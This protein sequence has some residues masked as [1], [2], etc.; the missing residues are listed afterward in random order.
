[1]KKLFLLFLVIFL[2]GCIAN[3]T[4]STNEKFLSKSWS[5]NSFWKWGELVG[6]A[7]LIALFI[8]VLAYFAGSFFTSPELL[9]WSKKEIGQLIYSC[10][11][12]IFVLAL[13]ASV[14]IYLEDIIKWSS[15]SP[16]WHTYI[17]IICCRSDVL[18]DCPYTPAFVRNNPCHFGIAKDYLQILYETDK[19]QLDYS[20]WRYGIFS[21]LSHLKLSA[22]AEIVID[23]LDVSINVAP[24][25]KVDEEYYNILI[26]YLYKNMIFIRI[27][28]LALDYLDLVLVPFMIGM[29]L[30]LR[31]FSFSRKLGGTLIALG[32]SFYIVLP[33]FYSLMSAILFG[34][35]G[36]WIS[37]NSL[38]KRALFGEK[39]ELDETSSKIL[40]LDTRNQA[41]ARGEKLI[42]DENQQRKSEFEEFID[43]AVSVFS[44]IEGVKTDE[45]GAKF[46]VG[47]ALSNLAALMTFTVITPF[48]GL[49]LTL[50]SYKVLS[51]LIGGDV[52]IA[53]LSRL[54]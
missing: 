1:M 30:V 51:P 16:D 15:P 45:L 38:G 46:K 37:G 54:I 36:S 40:Q 28:Q 35:T 18:S 12:I 13:I 44:N 11:I 49:M 32:L 42:C 20:L 29:G 34:F 8:L 7:L 33:T 27:Q 10:L 48:I 31:I 22:R 17:D 53:L 24:F 52:E 9:A 5:E 4:T 43:Q 26:D 41:P 2:S 19:E 50:S 39:I 23:L 47:S 21:I 25:L 14:D 3:T 6:T